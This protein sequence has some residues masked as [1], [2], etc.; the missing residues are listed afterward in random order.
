MPANY[1]T[2]VSWEAALNSVQS[3]FEA[4]AYTIV[5]PHGSFAPV[6]TD[7]KI[8]MYVQLCLKIILHLS[9][10]CPFSVLEV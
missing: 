2:L 1:D 6:R 3:S 10:G 4:M 7:G 9:I 8:I 5:N